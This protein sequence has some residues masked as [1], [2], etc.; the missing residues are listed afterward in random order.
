MVAPTM[1][2]DVFCKLGTRG[3]V[4]PPPTGFEKI[5]YT[6]RRGL[7]IHRRTVPTS[8]LN[9]VFIIYG[10]ENVR[11]VWNRAHGRFPKETLN[12]SFTLMPT[13]VSVKE[14]FAELFSKSDR[15]SY[16]RTLS[17]LTLNSEEEGGGGGVDD[18]ES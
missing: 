16:V 10:L 12:T 5:L 6:D 1:L 7:K 17:L 11:T 14:V 2:K 3:V 15:I 9:D 4:A 13:G 18:L 8:L